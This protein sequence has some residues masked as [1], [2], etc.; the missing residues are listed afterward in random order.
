MTKW[1]ISGVFIQVRPENLCQGITK[2]NSF[3]FQVLEVM[4]PFLHRKA[5]TLYAMHSIR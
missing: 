3:T 2:K 1:D 4:Q 5:R